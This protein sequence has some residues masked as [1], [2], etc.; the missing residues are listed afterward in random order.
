[1][2][3]FN[4][5]VA[6]DLEGTLIS[7]AVRPVPRPYL[8]HFLSYCMKTFNN[9]VIYSSVKKERVD[10]VWSELFVQGF[11]PEELREIKSVHWK[12][13]YKNLKFI[14][15]FEPKQ[16]VLIDDTEAWIEP[17]QK[18]QWIKIKQWSYPFS[19]N[20]QELKRIIALLKLTHEQIHPTS[21]SNSPESK[22]S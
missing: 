15:G 3:N 20:D 9:V 8:N 19:N 7:S 18:S 16:I 6:L 22:K 4:K 13:R 2:C 10:S 21:D 1:M 5:V 17:S 12:G 11:I 14:K